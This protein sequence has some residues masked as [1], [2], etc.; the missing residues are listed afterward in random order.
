MVR[1]DGPSV[2]AIALTVENQKSLFDKLGN[3]VILQP[4]GTPPLVKEFVSQ[5]LR[6]CCSPQFQ[7]SLFGQAVGQTEREELDEIL[8]VEVRGYP[9]ECQPLWSMPRR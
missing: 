6:S 5:A 9:L 8:R 7:R 4:A 3:S 2:E 1:H